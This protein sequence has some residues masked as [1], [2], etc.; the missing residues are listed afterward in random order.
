MWI[1]KT[2]VDHHEGQIVF[3]TETGKGTTFFV[4]LP[5]QHKP[6]FIPVI[7]ASVPGTNS[8]TETFTKPAF[9]K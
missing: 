4:G 3:E 5:V 1:S 7:L 8:F 2:T 6:G 9:S